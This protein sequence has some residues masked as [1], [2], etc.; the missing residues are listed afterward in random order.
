MTWPTPYKPDRTASVWGRSPYCPGVRWIR[1]GMPIASTTACS[2]VASPPHERPMAATSAPPLR[3]SHRHDP[4]RWC[5]RSGHIR[6]LACRPV[7]GKVFPRHPP[8]TNVE[9][10]RGPQSI[11]RTRPAGHASVLHCRP[12]TRSRPR[13]ADCLR[14][15][16][17]AFRAGRE[18]GLRS[19]SI[20]R[21]SV[22]VCSRPA[23]H[24]QP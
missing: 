8:V 24:R 22:S 21:P 10:E 23:L 16:G 17:R 20:V 3:P 11:C 5:C 19:G 7:H 2:L 9:N 13:T 6:S 14:H 1:S 18:D 4:S 12:S 15:S